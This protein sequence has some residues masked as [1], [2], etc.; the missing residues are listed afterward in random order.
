MPDYTKNRKAT[1]VS[2]PKVSLPKEEV[3]KLPFGGKPTTKENLIFSFS[4]FDRSHKLFNLGGIRDGWFLDLL[5]CLKN[6]S[7]IKIYET[8][9]STYD[10]H[11]VDWSIS[12]TPK[13]ESSEQYEFW[14]FRINK[15]KGRIIGIL[16]DAV[17]YVVWLDP[18]HNLTNSEGY[19]GPTYYSPGKSEYEQNIEILKE[20]KEENIKLKAELKASEDL[21]EEQNK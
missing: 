10:L 19:R 1:D 12:N 20:L 4:C 9:G 17:F 3:I 8:K 14:Q 13:P 15:S 5:D 6:I 21:L 2:L 11:P 18:H 16:I 7:I